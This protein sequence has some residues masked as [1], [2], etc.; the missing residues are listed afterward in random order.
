SAAFEATYGS[1]TR[2]TTQH[3]FEAILMTPV[4]VSDL[5]VGEVIWG[6]TKGLVSGIIMLISL[7]LF[8]V[9]PSPLV[10]ALIPILFLE[11]VFFSALGLITTAVADNYEFFNYF[12][13][14]LITPLFLFS[15]VFFPIDS[16]NP[17]AKAVLLA[18]PLTHTVTLARRFCY[19]DLSG[20]WA[21]NLSVIAA[22]ALTA[23]WISIMLLR[24][25]LIR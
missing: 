11:V 19:G 4:S 18:L 15:G 16:L 2:L 21:L 9:W 24:R 7:P 22:A 6:A 5:A 8:G 12:T 17:V 20:G 10:L 13:S 3:T 1:Y 14:L 23:A 25:R